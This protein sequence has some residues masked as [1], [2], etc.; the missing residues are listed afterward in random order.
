MR[1]AIPCALPVSAALLAASGVFAEDAAPTPPVTHY[2]HNWTDGNGANH[3]TCCA[4]SNF[5]L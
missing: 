1:L 4:L 3:R 2:W 5:V